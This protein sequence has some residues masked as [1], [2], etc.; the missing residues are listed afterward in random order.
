MSLGGSDS[1][2]MLFLR[3]FVE[4]VNSLIKETTCVLCVCEHAWL[5]IREGEGETDAVLGQK[6]PV[7]EQK[8]PRK[9]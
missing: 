2:S 4:T 1:L 7:L 6:K 9:G 8:K 3:L 5:C